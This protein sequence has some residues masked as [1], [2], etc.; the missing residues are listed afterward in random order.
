MGVEAHARH[1]LEHDEAAEFRMMDA[2]GPDDPVL[3][4]G[5][6]TERW[7]VS[8]DPVHLRQARAEHDE[9]AAQIFDGSRRPHLQQVRLK[10]SVTRF[11]LSLRG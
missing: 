2:A 3:D 10:P 4:R 8:H 1:H 6:P 11:P 9:H 7:R 5:D